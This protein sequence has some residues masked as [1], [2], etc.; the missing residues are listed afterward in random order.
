M[1]IIGRWDAHFKEENV[2]SFLAY[3]LPTYAFLMS[4]LV[5]ADNIVSNSE[6]ATALFHESYCRQS[7]TYYVRTHRSH[8]TFPSPTFRRVK[9]LPFIDL[10]TVTLV[11]AA[12]FLF[13]VTQSISH[14]AIFITT[15]E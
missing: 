10:G 5:I 4:V 8:M 11:K 2:V 14:I 12:Y 7:D 15:R 9:M 6:E 13:F 1:K 3:C